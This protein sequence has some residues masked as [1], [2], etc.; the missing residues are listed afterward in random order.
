MNKTQEALKLPRPQRLHK[1][2]SWITF[3]RRS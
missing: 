2:S 1:N 3:I